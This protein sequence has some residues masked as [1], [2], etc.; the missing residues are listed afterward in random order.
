MKTKNILP[1]IVSATVLAIT[2]AAP[3]PAAAHY[4]HEK[5][6]VKHHAGKH[7]NRYDK[8]YHHKRPK[9]H[10][11]G[12]Y[13]HDH[14]YRYSHNRYGKSYNSGLYPVLGFIY[15][16]DWKDNHYSYR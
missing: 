8:F 11:Y 4:E 2:A 16:N 3:L 12:Y 5:S 9:G 6:Y 7:H 15:Y 13:K 14:H 1:A 10:A